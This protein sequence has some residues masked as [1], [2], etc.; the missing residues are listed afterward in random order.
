[1]STIAPESASALALIAA[2]PKARLVGDAD[3]GIRQ[4]SC[5]PP[6]GGSGKAAPSRTAT[7]E[8]SV[9]WRYAARGL[10]A[11][12]GESPAFRT[13][14]NEAGAA[15]LSGEPLP[16][17]NM[18]ILWRAA[19]AQV[20]FEQ[21]Q[22][23]H[24]PLV[25]LLSGPS[26]PGLAGQQGKFGCADFGTVPLMACTLPVPPRVKGVGGSSALA[27]RKAADVADLARVRRLIAQ[28]FGLEE[29]PLSR[30]FA[31][32][33]LERPDVAVYLAERSGQAVSTVI[34]TRHGPHAAL[35]SM[36]TPA[37][38]QG[39]GLGRALLSEVMQRECA[40]GMETFFL[41]STAAGQR[42]YQQ[43][44]FRAIDEARVWLRSQSTENAGPQ[45]H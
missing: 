45:L 37:G 14:E 40:D 32:R 11:L 28:A 21:I 34:V 23:T 36:A 12:L 29:A 10:C 19:G 4:G 8:P 15:A 33:L 24:L 35:W 41:L 5:I 38:L 6:R 27:V 18:C 30:A 26:A 16:D 7:L 39:Q 31:D 1:M 9:L 20:L 3:G 2:K 13:I 22:A 43:L 44:G 25:F 42:L 17:L